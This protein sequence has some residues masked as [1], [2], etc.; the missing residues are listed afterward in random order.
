MQGLRGTWES[1][2]ES[3]CKS[4]RIENTNGN[5]RFWSKIIEAYQGVLKHWNFRN[6]GVW[7][8]G[9]GEIGPE[10]PHTFRTTAS[11]SRSGRCA[12]LGRAFGSRCRCWCCQWASAG[13]LVHLVIFGPDRIWSVL[14]FLRPRKGLRNCIHVFQVHSKWTHEHLMPILAV[15]VSLHAFSFQLLNVRW[16]PTSEVFETVELN[17]CHRLST[18]W[19]LRLLVKQFQTWF[20]Q[21]PVATTELSA[22]WLYT[23][24]G[25]KTS[26]K[27]MK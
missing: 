13:S 26:V 6:F 15:F 7:P 8:G 27:L 10:P 2:D 11:G 4:R 20:F 5:I 19:G 16:I 23:K 18:C 17:L 1:G 14:N 9:L 21:E 24:T 25:K 12:A 22:L 3:G